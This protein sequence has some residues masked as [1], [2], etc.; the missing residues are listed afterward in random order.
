MKVQFYK[1]KFSIVKA[2][3]FGLIKLNYLLDPGCVIRHFVPFAKNF[4]QND[5]KVKTVF[6][7][8]CLKANFGHMSVH[9]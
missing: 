9:Q 7:T 5:L 8:F 4:L 6:D 3:I 2:F 1:S